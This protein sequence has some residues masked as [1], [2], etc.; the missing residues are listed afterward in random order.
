M[1]ENTLVYV[2]TYTSRPPH[3][4]SM[5]QSE[6]I[7]LLQLNTNTGELT[8][9][10]VVSR[11]KNPSY[12][13]IDP[14][15]RHLYAVS[16]ATDEQ[17]GQPYGAVSAFQIDPAS[18]HLTLINH[19]PSHG[20]GPCHVWVDAQGKWV[21]VANYGS[22]SSAIYPVQADGGL[23]AATDTVQHEGSG[24]NPARQEGP[25]AHCILT[26]PSNRFV[27]IMDLGLDKVMVYRLEANGKL[28][29]SSHAEVT[30]GSGPRH[31]DFH[32][33]GRY[34]FLINEM[35]STITVFAYNSAVGTLQEIQT[36][37]TLPDGFSSDDYTTAAIHVHP[38]GKFVYGSNRGHNSIAIFACDG[39]TGK[40]T[41]AG[42][43]STQGRTP[44]D[45]VIDPTGQFLLAA[46]QDSDDIYVYR[47]DAQTGSLTPTGFS[48]QVP[49]PVC[50]KT[51]SR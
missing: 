11:V 38:S 14:T 51:L 49:I 20:R 36:L 15:Q 28:T 17:D 18:G 23:G 41:P 42:H 22:G 9:V 26:D 44:R 16:E 47:V 3:V 5:G 45:F 4:R 39:Q 7:Y 32:P 30:G 43:V 10:G 48:V 35:A 27:L 13:A 19:Q 8:S 21:L 37:S 25:H 1:A 2:G 46:N 6:G 34:G 31:F 12:L 29:R 33:N 40:L 24:I 50:L